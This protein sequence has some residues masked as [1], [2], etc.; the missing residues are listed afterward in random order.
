[1]LLKIST[2][3]DQKQFSSQVVTAKDDWQE[4]RIELPKISGSFELA[5]HVTDGSLQ[6]H[7]VFLVEE[8]TPSVD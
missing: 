8:A 6:V 7:H 2:L 5:L 3:I 1:M 4:L